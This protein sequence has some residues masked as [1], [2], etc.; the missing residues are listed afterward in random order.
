MADAKDLVGLVETKTMLRVSHA[1]QDAEIASIITQTTEMLEREADRQFVLRD[2]N[3]VTEWHDLAN[4]QGFLQLRLFPAISVTSLFIGVEST[5]PIDSDL[6]V[7]D[8][9]GAVIMMKGATLNPVRPGPILL[10][11]SGAGGFNAFD[12]P[13][14][15]WRLSG[16]FF[17]ASVGGA[18]AVYKGGY[19][20]TASVEGGLKQIAFDVLARRYRAR[21]RK[22]QGLTQQVAQGF[23]IASKW[24]PSLLTNEEKRRLQRF[25]TRSETAR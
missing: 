15:A 18:R 11:G 2:A 17:P 20:D 13:E 3:D 21:E 10:R 8:L 1:N 7:V 14:D 12:F 16:R 5:T 22:S 19:T 23:T 24:D 25:V 4:P 6:F 9:A